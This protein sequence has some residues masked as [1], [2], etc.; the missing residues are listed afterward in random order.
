MKK[1]IRVECLSCGHLNTFLRAAFKKG[2]E[3]GCHNCKGRIGEHTEDFDEK[4]AATRPL[5]GR[6]GAEGAGIDSF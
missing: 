1:Y 5:F 6:R 4:I 3:N 2:I